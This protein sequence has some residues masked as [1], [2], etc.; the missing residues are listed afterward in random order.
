M[1]ITFSEIQYSMLR[2]NNNNSNSNSNNSNNMKRKQEMQ[3]SNEDET[4]KSK[5]NTNFSEIISSLKQRLG[6]EQNALPGINVSSF[7]LHW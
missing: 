1:I 3:E 2:H 6:E 7:F 5:M 4:K